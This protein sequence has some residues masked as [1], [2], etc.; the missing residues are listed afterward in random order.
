IC[1]RIAGKEHQE[2][3]KYIDKGELAIVG[4]TYAILESG[5][6][7]M[8]GSLA[9]LIWVFVHIFFLI[10]FKNRFVVLF[11]YALAYL[12]LFQQNFGARIIFNRYVHRFQS[13][14]EIEQAG[15][16]QGRS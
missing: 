13:H 4:R 15:V 8:S 1:D 12:N 11:K 9:W 2:P 14:R 6:I 3:F 7:R 10:G 16:G 5:P